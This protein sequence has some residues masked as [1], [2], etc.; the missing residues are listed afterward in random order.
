MGVQITDLLEKKEVE[1]SDLDGKVFA[2]D[3]SLWLYQFLSIIRQRDGTPLMDSH[4]NV[5]SH[6]TGLFSRTA[7]LMTR[8]LKLAYVFDGKAPE[9]KT[10]E[11]KKRRAAK[12]EAEK[13]YRIAVEK[14]DIAEMKKYASRTSRLTGDMI[15]EAK[16][17]IDA[18]GLPVVQAPSEGEAQAS[19][20]VKKGDAFAVASQDADCFL[21]GSPKLVRNLSISGRKKISGKLGYKV[22]KPEIIDMAETLN[23]LGIDNDQLIAVGMLVGTDYNPGGIKGIGPKNALKLVRESKGDLDALFKKV[24]WGKHNEVDW[25]EIFYLFKKMPLSDS[26]SLSWKEPD[27]SRIREILVEK[28]DFSEERVNSTMEKLVKE[29]KS[30]SQKG[31]GEF[32]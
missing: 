21:F 9:L 7:N 24:G 32:F 16:E 6:L 14:K 27:I 8:G 29:M 31:L 10:R 3:S 19:Y 15:S 1:I 30:K 4:G 22:I 2:V 12:L 5:T 26:Y 11:R 13:K 25:N 20:L 23:S 28:H 18:L 17:L